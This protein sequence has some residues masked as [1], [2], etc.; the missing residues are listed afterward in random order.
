MANI[1]PTHLR[2]EYLIDPL[3]IDA[4][5]PRLSWVLESKQ[6]NQNQ[7]GYHILVSSKMKLLNADEGDLWDSGKVDSDQTN[8]IEYDGVPLKSK[9]FCFWKVRVWDDKNQASE[10]SVA[11]KWSMGLLKPSD[12]KAKW[13]GE[14]ARRDLWIKKILPK[15]REDPCPLL[16]KSFS[17][18]SSFKRAIVHV[19]ALG[20]YELYLNETKVGENILSPEWTDYDVRVQYQTYDVTALLKEGKNVIGAILA[21][22]WYKGY[23]GPTGYINDVYGVNRRFIL[24]L[25]IE[26]SNGTTEEIISDEAWRIWRDG[27]IRKSDHFMGEIYDVRKE[28][29]RWNEPDFDDLNWEFVTVDN[30]VKTKLVSQMNEPI[31][32][33]KEI[34][35][36]SISEPKPG[37]FIFNLGQNIAGFCKIKLNDSIC[38]DGARIQLRHGEMLDMNGCLYTKN[39]RTAKATDVY[40][41]HG[42]EE[43]EFCPHFTYHGFQYVELTGLKPGIKPDLA[44]LTGCAIASSVPLTGSFE[45]SNQMLNQLWK[46]I[47]WTQWD[48]LISV[49][50]DCPQRDERMGWMGDA[51]VFS[52]T[53]MFNM[54][55]AAFYTKW[56]RDI[57]DGQ[58]ES[59]AYPDIIPYS[60]K[61]ARK[62]KFIKYL[63]IVN[64]PG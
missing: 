21:D 61:F 22:G 19:S 48:N 24:Q 40:I 42:N 7:T 36:I 35:P 44:M 34:K 9:M 33:I 50:T 13:I 20:H 55:M 53:S 25:S 16:R 30:T 47:L 37:K 15:L 31:K 38:D 39:L 43:R 60:F 58:T 18:K 10:W 28:Q 41:Y 3:G 46:N 11:A 27:P 12:W 8:Q 64:S 59:G 4:E 54:D 51:Q 63:N 57:R 23:L 29:L 26:K 1:F 49:P 6:R 17:V 56:I 32:I 52:Q 45:C 5:K 14:P 62:L 2:C